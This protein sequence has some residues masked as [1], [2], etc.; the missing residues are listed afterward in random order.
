VLL[1]TLAGVVLVQAWIAEDAYITFRMVENFVTGHGLTWNPGQ[2]VMAATHPLWLGLLIAGRLLTGELY[3]TA[4]ALSIGLTLAAAAALVRP[5]AP[6]AAAMAL[7]LLIGS[8]G[9]V[10]FSTAGLEGALAHLL[11]ALALG[12]AWRGRPAAVGWIAGLALLNRLDAVFLLAPLVAA[13]LWAAP[14]AARRRAVLAL[15]PLVL[16]LA[17]SV[18]Y[19]GSPLPNTAAAKLNLDLPLGRL[20][21]QGMAYLTNSARLDPLLSWT[22]AAALVGAIWR[23]ERLGLA[24]MAGVLLHGLWV[25]RVGGDFMSGRFLTTPFLASAAV[26]ARALPVRVVPVAA[27]AGLTL[28]LV[29]PRGPLRAGLDYDHREL[30]NAAIADE[31]GYYFQHTGLLPMWR[32]GRAPVR[33][34]RPDDGVERSRVTV[35]PSIGIDGYMAGPAVHVIDTMALADPLLARIPASAGT[36]RVGHGEREIPVGYRETLQSGENLLEDPALAAAW[37]DISRVTQGGLFDD[38]RFAAMVRL[39]TQ[40]RRLPERRVSGG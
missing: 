3:F 16:W 36:W 15:I 38:G 13:V 14:R 10:D 24:V 31:R 1:A 22:V 35:M 23:R 19:F 33:P 32:R 29:N 12:M 37:D 8:K 21:G 34:G 30:D 5:L 40:H 4:L 9:F 27:A 7:L 26:L 11:V 39:W 20:A 2:R 25:L 18:L 17:F 28:S 6:P